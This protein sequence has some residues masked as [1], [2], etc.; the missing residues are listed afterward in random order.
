MKGHDGI[1]SK[2]SSCASVV[3]RDENK[4]NTQ[5]ALA[6]ESKDHTED[7]T[8]AEVLLENTA[9]PGQEV[10]LKESLPLTQDKE[11]VC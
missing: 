4:V 2:N 7:C 8:A 3:S 9:L 6:S 10:V 11:N 5:N 1:Y